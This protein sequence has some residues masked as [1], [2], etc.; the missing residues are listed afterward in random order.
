M[1]KKNTMKKMAALAL[2][3]AL[4]V[5]ATGC[6]FVVTDNEKDLAQTVA[7]VNITERLKQDKTYK[8]S[9]DDLSAIIGNLSADI[10]KRDLIAY[11]MSTGY[12]YVESYGYTYEDTFNML[13]DNLISSEIMVQY[14]VAYYFKQG[15]EDGSITGKKCQEYIASELAKVSNKKEKELLKA[16]PEV[17]TLKYF[18]TDGGKNENDATEEYNPLEEYERTVYS[19]KKS[20]NNSLDSM[21]ANYVKADEEEHDHEEARTLPTNVGTQKSDYYTNDYGVYTGRNTVDSCGEYEAIDGSTTATRRKAYNN[22]LANLKGYNL[23]STAKGAVEDTKDV[24][25]LDYYYVELGSALGSALINKYFE[26]LQDS[27]INSLDETYVTKKYDEMLAKQQRNYEGDTSAFDSALG[28]VSDTSFVLYGLED[29]G[30]VYNILI[31]FSDVQNMQY[32]E[33]QGMGI[34]Q[35]QQFNVRRDLLAEVEGED[36]RS[37]WISKH[38]HANY[39]YQKDGDDNYYF[40]KDNMQTPDKYESLKHYAGLIPYNGTVV[41]EDDEYKC[42]SNKVSVEDVLGELDKYLDKISDG[43]LSFEGDYDSRY[44]KGDDYYDEKENVDYSN[45][46]YYKGNVKVNGV[47]MKDTQINPS[48]YHKE[49]TDLYNMV[50]VVNEL[51]FAYSTDT[52]CLN[53]YMGYSISPYSTNYMPEF[54]F[55]A[56]EAV[57]DGVG[58]VIVAPTDYGWHIIITS[59]KYL[60]G[61]VYSGYNHDEREVEGTFSYYFYESLKSSAASSYASEVQANV[62]KEYDNE[63]SVTRFEKAYKDLLE[64]DN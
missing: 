49:G 59:A 12:Q 34:T 13:L 9:V 43:R 15:E 64:L 20:I 4:T 23:I 57:K 50:S 54:E 56:Q 52:G 47:A 5:G 36:L 35:T 38:D 17:L 26:D 32:S 45:F 14:A 51:M 8:N 62:L 37:S 42:T 48:D 18:L 28:S 30:F 22:F 25:L 24:T 27:V 53:S 58:T 11:F 55:A 7:T 40:F 63:D 29:F 1:N 2:G 31:P 41:E 10:T 46:V 61:N 60:G 39:S 19:L 3:M 6:D 16:H 21:E 44:E 33:A